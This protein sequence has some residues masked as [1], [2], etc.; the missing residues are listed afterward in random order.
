MVGMKKIHQAPD[1]MISQGL[2][3]LTGDFS[4]FGEDGGEKE[5]FT[6]S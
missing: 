5:F 1:R 3:S 2:Q 4:F 6:T